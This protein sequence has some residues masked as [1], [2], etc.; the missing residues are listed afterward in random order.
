[1]PDKIFPRGR[2]TLLFLALLAHTLLIPAASWLGALCAGLLIPV[3]CMVFLA[4][5]KKTGTSSLLDSLHRAPK[6]LRRVL[7]LLLM[8]VAAWFALRTAQNSASFLID[9]TL[10]KWQLWLGVIALL[11]LGWL[12]ARQGAPALFLWA[13][14][15]AWFAG[16]IIFLSL[17][18]SVSDWQIDKSMLT[19]AFSPGD[20]FR[21]FLAVLPTTAALLLFSGHDDTLPQGK[22]LVLGGLCAALLTGL[23][24]FRA[25]AVLGANCAR[26]ITYPAYAAAGVFELG[27]LA[28]S[29]IIFG[30]AFALCMVA[31]IALF[32]AVVR[33]SWQLLR[34]KS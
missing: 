25:S 14:P 15:M 2:G 22:A 31:R 27:T 21:Q 10:V 13:V 4:L 32:C 23:T 28:R 7:A 17:I 1:M 16:L 6:W 24:V 33:T 18:L 26:A 19:G 34:G 11:V 3:I 12:I 30:M 9:T 8:V 29:E 20:V 5:C